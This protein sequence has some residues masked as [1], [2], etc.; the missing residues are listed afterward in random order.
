MSRPVVALLAVVLALA[1]GGA[2]RAETPREAASRAEALLTKGDFDGALAAYA[3]AARADRANQ[4]YVQKYALVRRVIQLR[5]QLETEQDAA[6][7]EYLAR[8]LYNFYVNGHIYT[9]A[10]ALGEKLHARLQN[11]SSAAML[12]ETQ[13]AVDRSADAARMLASLKPDQATP[14]TQALL[15]IALAREGKVDEARKVAAAIKLSDGAGP[16]AAYT[17]A[18]LK[19]RLG[20]AEAASALLAQCLKD[21][22]PSMIDGYREHARACPD[23]TA[24]ASGAAFS[25]ALATESEVPESK[26]SGGAS[27]AGCPMRGKCADGAEK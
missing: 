21:T 24:V 19:A 10:L 26:C 12:A 13:L 4:D 11:A 3:A 7:W 2:A 6:R 5:K 14:V 15:G 8:G 16:R 27:C 18:R 23:F 1:C 25:K 17:V 20:D 22:P 9:E